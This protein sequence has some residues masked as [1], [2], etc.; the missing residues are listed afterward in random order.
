[1]LIMQLEK[2]IEIGAEDF[3][4]VFVSLQDR[5]AYEWLSFIYNGQIRNE[6]NWHDF[7]QRM[8]ESKVALRGSMPRQ[9]HSLNVSVNG[10]GMNF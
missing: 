2:A 8:I 4:V 10:L 7:R 3:S 6:E 5:S 9:I 1:M